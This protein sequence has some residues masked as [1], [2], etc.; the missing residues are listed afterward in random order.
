[1]LRISRVV[2]INPLSFMAPASSILDTYN[3]A[4]CTLG[5]AR[6]WTAK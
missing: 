1:M 5:G 6:C 4:R 2:G 3:L